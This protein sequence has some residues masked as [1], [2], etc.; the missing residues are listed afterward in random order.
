[1]LD[2]H[3]RRDLAGEGVDLGARH[4]VVEPVDHL[5]RDAG[6]VDEGRVEAEAEVPQLARQPRRRQRGRRP[7]RLDDGDGPLLHV[8]RLDWL[9]RLARRASIAA[10]E[11]EGPPSSP[12][13]EPAWEPPSRR[14]S[15]RKE[16]SSPTEQRTPPHRKANY[17]KPS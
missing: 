4:A 8:A 7:V 9:A 17:E 12:A 16:E 6:R 13:G 1:M 5:P 2:A 14:K 10:G 15:R 11:C 3:V